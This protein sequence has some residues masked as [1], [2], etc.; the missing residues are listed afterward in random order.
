MHKIKGHSSGDVGND[1]ADELAKFSLD[2]NSSYDNRFTHRSK[3]FRF[4][5]Q[6]NQIPI[7]QNIRNLLTKRYT[8]EI[9]VLGLN[10]NLTWIILPINGLIVTGKL[11]EPQLNK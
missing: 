10:S 11:P 2:L 3:E 5:L 4:I 6:Y 8:S 1:I 7:K 9:M